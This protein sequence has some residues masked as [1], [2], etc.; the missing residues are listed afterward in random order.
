MGKRTSFVINRVVFPTKTAATRHCSGILGKPGLSEE[1][2]AFLRDLI[3]RHPERDQKVG[4][5][6]RR[7]FVAADGFGRRCF[8]LERVDGSR[9]DFSFKSCLTPPTHETDV[10]QALRHL[11]TEQIIA[12]RDNAFSLS[13]EVPCAI[14]GAM[15]NSDG[16]HI[17]HRPPLT[18]LGLIESFFAGS[19]L[20]YETVP[21]KPTAD[22]DT[23]TYLA[24]EQIANAWCEYHRANAVLQIVTKRANLSQGGARSQGGGST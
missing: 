23:A 21:V 2:S 19:G 6:I 7:F 11:I 1:D 5:G 8:W 15:V 4:V 9:T 10:R 17:D 24:D 3:E 16:S 22:G 12:F 20:S 13:P 14:T 18:F